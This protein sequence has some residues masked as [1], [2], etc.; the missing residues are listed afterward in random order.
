[1]ASRTK[2]TENKRKAKVVAGGKSRKRA[3]RNGST[4]RFPVHVEAAPDAVL[5]MPPRSNPIE[6]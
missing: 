4:P 2:V 1:M 3:T 6:K 5:P